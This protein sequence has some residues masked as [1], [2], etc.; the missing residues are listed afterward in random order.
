M[1][2]TIG[3]QAVK[4]SPRLVAVPSWGVPRGGAP[5]NVLVEL[6]VL[7]NEKAVPLPSHAF[8]DLCNLDPGLAVASLKERGGTI[9]LTL[10]GGQGA[11]TYYAGF[12][13]AGGQLMARHVSG[14]DVAGNER[15][16]STRYGK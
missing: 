11:N 1:K 2:V 9:R 15:V 4:P 7:V 3:V 8:D 5:Q 12:D 14:F 6:K 10:I 16:E 13:I